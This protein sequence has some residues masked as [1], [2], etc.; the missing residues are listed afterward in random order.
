MKK[1]LFFLLFIFLFSNAYANSKFDKD[2][3]KFSKDSGFIDDKGEIYPHDQISNKKEIILII[4]NHGS[5]HDQATD[6]CTKPVLPFF[7]IKL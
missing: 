2:L 5:D 3:K 1:I 6:N 7:S 4:Y